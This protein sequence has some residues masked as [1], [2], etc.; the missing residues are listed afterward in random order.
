[1][2][3]SEVYNMDCLEYMRTLPDD[4]FDLCIAD[5]PYGD[6]HHAEDG[7]GKGWFTKYN[8][9]AEDGLYAAEHR[10][11]R[12]RF[13]RYNN[14]DARSQSVQVERERKGHSITDSEAQ[15]AGSRDTSVTRT[16]GTRAAKYGKKS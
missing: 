5:P 2:P 10:N 6:G 15:G 3:T 11:L 4:A 14:T 7:G 8:M 16:G 12:G 13:D 9:K 1:M